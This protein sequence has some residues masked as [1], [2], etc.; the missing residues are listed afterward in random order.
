MVPR[1]RNVAIALRSSLTWASENFAAT[2]AIRIACSWNSG[3]PLVLPRI[4]RNSSGGP[5]SGE[6]AG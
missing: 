2:M 1:L 6:G 4:W 5:C 3:T